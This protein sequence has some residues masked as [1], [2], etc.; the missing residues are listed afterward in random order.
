MDG[1]TLRRAFSGL[2]ATETAMKTGRVDKNLA[3][4]LFVLQYT[5][6]QKITLGA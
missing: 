6:G 4:E 3:F 5:S 1:K 2:V